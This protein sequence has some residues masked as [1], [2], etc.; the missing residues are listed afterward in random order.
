[1]TLLVPSTCT[2][3]SG[4]QPAVRGEVCVGTIDD[5]GLHSEHCLIL[6]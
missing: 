1:V 5:R 2:G 3:L 4:P 6:D